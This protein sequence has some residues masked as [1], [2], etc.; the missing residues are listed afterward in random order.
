MDLANTP[1]NRSSIRKADRVKLLDFDPWLE[2]YERDLRMRKNRF[3]EAM[4]FILSKHESAKAFASGHLYF[5]IH[6]TATGWVYREWAPAAKQLYLM[7]D[8]NGW[9]R[10]SHPMRRLE[11]GAWEIELSRA[12]YGA[13]FVHGSCVKVHVVGEHSARDRI[14]LYIRRVHQYPGTSDFAGQLWFPEKPFE[15]SD[16]SFRVTSDSP[17]FIYETHVGMAQEREGIGSYLEF[18]E[19]I[20]PR[21]KAAGYNAVQIMAIAEHPYYGSFGYHVSNFF[22]PSS[23]FGTPEEL[24]FLVNRAHELGI[25]VLLDIVH[26]HAVKNTNDGINEFDGT[27]YQ[28]FHEGGKGEHPAWDSK[29]FDYGRMEVV[30]FL[31][32]NVRYWLEEFHFDGFRFDG[33][34]SMLYHHHGLGHAFDHYGKYFSMDTDTDAVLYLQLANLVAHETR[35]CI[36]IAEDMSGMPGMC[37]PVQDGG[38]GFDY[39]LAMGIPDFWIK[40]LKSQKDEDWNM[41]SM[42]HELT[43]RRPHERNIGYAESHDQA[44]VGDKTIAFWLM[45]ADMYW[46]MRESDQN[47]AV[48][49]GMALHKMIRLVTMALGGEGYLNFMGNEFGHPEW[50]DFPREGNGWSCKYARRQWSLLDDPNLKYKF[51]GRFDADMLAMARERNLPFASDLQQLWNCNE[52]K[53]LVF[54]KAGLIFAFNFHPSYSVADFEFWLDTPGEYTVALNSDSSYYGGHERIDPAITYRSYKR[55]GE[56]PPHALRI[57]LPCRSAIVLAPV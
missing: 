37:V 5:G 22:A 33:V 1:Q 30:H 50:I 12:E 35:P 46:H 34:T 44:L 19:T 41:N 17:P 43:T 11:H 56:W 23:R 42:W 13:T 32:S 9:N 6:P 25:A 15:W 38:I 28:F 4:R 48:D 36:T 10:S 14:P 40:T 39:R 31:L 18:A 24:K 51:L 27:V 16:A 57:Y 52:R 54:K 20:L 21:V 29:L 7:G 47:L 3:F 2:P 26:S 53:L 45:D 55:S 8:F 49:R